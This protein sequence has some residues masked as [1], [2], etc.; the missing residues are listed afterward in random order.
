MC[1]SL[2]CIDHVNITNYIQIIVTMSIPVSQLTVEDAHKEFNSLADKVAAKY[3]QLDSVEFGA[4]GTPAFNTKSDELASLFNHM[5][6]LCHRL[7]LLMPTQFTS[8]CSSN[9][10]VHIFISKF[11]E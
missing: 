4:V 9:T 2:V 6:Q 3:E 8:C 1:F 7:N 5:S 11:V 10:E